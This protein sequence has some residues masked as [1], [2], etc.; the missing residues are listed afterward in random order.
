MRPRFL[1]SHPEIQAILLGPFHQEWVSSHAADE[2]Q[3]S[4]GGKCMQSLVNTAQRK[5]VNNQPWS[6]FCIYCSRF[7][8][9]H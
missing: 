3:V 4:I 7:N 2:S 9:L 1:L 6:I 8:P 5:S